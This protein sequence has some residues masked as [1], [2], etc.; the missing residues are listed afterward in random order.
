M[1]SLYG[2]LPPPVSSNSNKIGKNNDKN[3]SSEAEKNDYIEINKFLI[4]PAIIQKKIA[5]IKNVNKEMHSDQ[6]DREDE[7]EKY[8]K[9]NHIGAAEDS[10]D[11]DIYIDRDVR[12][13]EERATSNG[14]KNTPNGEKTQGK[15]DAHIEKIININKSVQD[16]LK[17]I[18]DRLHKIQRSNIRPEQNTSTNQLNG[19]IIPA[20]VEITTNIEVNIKKGKLQDH[21]SGSNRNNAGAR[22]PAP[23]STDHF[24]T[25]LY[26][27]YFIANANEDYDPNK[28]NDLNKIIKERKRKKIIMLAAQKKKLEEQRHLEETNKMDSKNEHNEY[29]RKKNYYGYD[30]PNGATAA[31]K[32]PFDS[33]HNNRSY[34]NSGMP[35]LHDEEKERNR[36]SLYNHYDVSGRNFSARGE[37]NPRERTERDKPSYDDKEYEKE[38]KTSDK[39]YEIA[40]RTKLSD[41]S[42]DDYTKKNK[43]VTNDTSEVAAPVKKDFA[44]RMMEKMGWKKGEG[45]GKDK[46][47]ITAPL[48]LQKVDK[49][50]GVIVQAP[51]ILKKHKS[52]DSQDDNNDDG[53]TLS[54]SNANLA[55]SNHG[56]SNNTSRIIRLS[57]L[58]TKGEVDETLK[59]EIEEEASKFGNLLNINIAIDN[60]LTDAYAVKIFCEYESNDQAQN[61]L[62]TFKGRTFAGRKVEAIFAT[63]EEYLSYGKAS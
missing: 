3:S 63:E 46:Q 23:P 5:N 55:H 27:K 2:D 21:N 30:Q 31:S 36:G 54:K 1:D 34:T 60:N 45:L 25:D 19:Q 13:N 53:N 41:P 18:S 43:E 10:C 4:T 26:E 58:V 61:A 38:S 44:T 51:D 47:G 40:N 48:I 52:S 7:T 35:L 6:N 17:K 15:D 14:G 59:E 29:D 32:F 28:P 22:E 62:N 16:D 33:D 49:R 20:K 9:H 8:P 56:L 11:S 42:N 39:F 24:Q 12:R 57:N 50:S 37:Y